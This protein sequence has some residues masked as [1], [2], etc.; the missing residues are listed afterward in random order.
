MG[1]I[2]ANTP[3]TAPINTYSVAKCIGKNSADTATL[4]QSKELINPKSA[5]KP[6]RYLINGE[7][8]D[9]HYPELSEEKLITI[10]YGIKIH[11][12]YESIEDCVTA[13]RN[14]FNDSLKDEDKAFYYEIPKDGDVCR[15]T[16]W[17]GY[18]HNAGDWLTISFEN[19]GSTVA[20]NNKPTKLRLLFQEGLMSLQSL[21][22]WGAFSQ[23]WQ[24]GNPIGRFSL[25]LCDASFKAQYLIPLLSGEDMVQAENLIS[26]IPPISG[27]YFVY[28]IITNLPA[29]QCMDGNAIDANTLKGL[30]GSSIRFAPIPYS[31]FTA[32]N[33]VA[34]NNPEGGNPSTSDAINVEIDFAELTTISAIDMTYRLDAFM[35]MLSRTSTQQAIVDVSVYVG[36]EDRNILFIDRKSIAF[37]NG[38]TSAEFAYELDLDKVD[39]NAMN[40]SVV[41]GVPLLRVYY[42]MSGATESVKTF[43]LKTN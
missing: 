41:D 29:T 39:G 7:S 1:Y 37:A 22:L 20:T 14:S 4:C 43:E 17:I 34:T 42:S 15:L 19:H 12:S 24:N 27:G 16:D 32:W 9:N 40:F 3:L 26:F 30:S 10:N 8:V 13:I 23:F 25:V 33:P 6:V 38:E 2:D 11:S 31:D 21:Q 28:P 36:T 5:R 35:L 18:K